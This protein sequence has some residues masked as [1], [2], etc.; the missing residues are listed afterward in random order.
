M[1][2][3]H[4][5]D[6]TILPG[7]HT[8]TL[9]GAWSDKKGMA[10]SENPVIQAFF[11]HIKVQV[12]D[13]R[14]VKFWEDIWIGGTSL[15]NVFPNL[16]RVSSQQK[17]VIGNMGWFEGDS[18]RWVLAWKRVLSLEESHKELQLHNIL[19]QHNP[20]R[21]AKDSL[22]WGQSDK[23]SIKSLYAKAVNQMENEGSVD[24]LVCSVWQKLALQRLSSWYG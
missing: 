21:S 2:S 16:Y 5:D 15:Q 7:R 23:F 17:E 3:I 19:Q 20:R 8:R 22:G 4:E 1:D 11:Q 13:G 18:W 24:R 10:I 14:R 9:T 6:I 12:G